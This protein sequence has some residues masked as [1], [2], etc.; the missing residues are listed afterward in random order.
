MGYYC[1]IELKSNEK[2]NAMQVFR[3]VLWSN[4]QL[5]ACFGRCVSGVDGVVIWFRL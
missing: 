2:F 5:Y 4:Y 1:Y 3:C